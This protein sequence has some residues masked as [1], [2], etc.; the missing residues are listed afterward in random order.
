MIIS[1][2]MGVPPALS[3][4]YSRG[5]RKVAISLLVTLLAIGPAGP[6]GFAQTTLPR[7]GGVVSLDFH[8]VDIQDV[9]KAISEITGKNFILDDRARGKV[10]IISPSPVS[11]EEAYQAFLSALSVKNLCAL[12]VGKITKI[13]PK[14]QC[15]TQGPEVKI[16]ATGIAGDAIV[17]QLVQLEYIEAN[18]IK[19]A[20]NGMVS[21]TG[22]IVAYGPTNTVIITDSQVNILRLLNIIQKL[23]RPFGKKSK[24]VIPLRYAEAADMAEKLT[25]IFKKEEKKTSR[26]RRR[27]DDVAAGAEV[28]QI[29]PDTRTNS[30]IVVATREGLGRILDLLSE[31]D[32]PVVPLPGPGKIHVR[33]IQHASAEDLAG[34]LSTLLGGASS[35]K[36]KKKGEGK[37]KEPRSPL[38][39]SSSYPFGEGSSSS[40]SSSRSSASKSSNENGSFVVGSGGIFEDEVR[41]VADPSQNSLIITAT[42]A[43]FAAID[44]V[45]DQLDQRRAQVFVE[46]LIMEVLLD[47]LTDVGINMHGAGAAG[48]MGLLGLSN[49]GGLTPLAAIS[50]SGAIEQLANPVSPPGMILGAVSKKNIKVGNIT[51]PLSGA[52]LKALQ[53]NK[54]LNVLSA[55]NILTTDNEEAEIFVGRKVSFKKGGYTDTSGNPVNQVS[56]EKTGITLKVTP[57]VN[58]GNEVTLDIEQEIE[59]VEPPDPSG[60]QQNDISTSKRS[61]KTTV[62]AQNLQTIVI[63]GL[64]SDKDIKSVNKVPLLGDIPLLGYLFRNTSVRKEKRNL[65]LFLTPHVIHEPEDLTRVSVKKNNERRRFY[66]THS[67]PENKALYDYNLDKGLNMAPPA[68]RADKDK[69]KKRKR[70]D[71]DHPS[72]FKKVQPDIDEEQ[73]RKRYRSSDSELVEA[74]YKENRS[75]DDS[76][77][78]HLPANGD[79]KVKNKPKKNSP[80]TDIRPPSSN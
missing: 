31:L 63:G 60:G 46:A 62:V 71:Y 6:S 70:F 80:F 64:I 28:S 25:A 22:S 72:E 45:I 68:P 1:T 33:K 5:M 42:P 75:V 74:S 13:V 69:D 39:T 73:T 55:P 2:C 26:R 61:A 49:L 43:D 17:T 65:I 14:R 27:S 23:D 30:L 24:E 40:D 37:K 9:V 44:S 54:A 4:L 56:R 78:Y 21:K 38:D 41:V 3:L 19:Q 57:H 77:G 66:K 34:I 35:S 76:F 58:S 51:L 52:T 79:L 59:E 47:K 12:E 10:T 11:I 16:S 53:T 50:K 20:I 29:I 15:K 8:D 18:E 67:I 32:K 48:M 7:A 36:K